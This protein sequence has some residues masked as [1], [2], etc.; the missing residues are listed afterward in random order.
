MIYLNSKENH[1]S[2][3]EQCEAACE[4]DKLCFQFLLHGKMCKLS[5]TIRLGREHVAATSEE[6]D[7]Y[8]SGWNVK[9]IRQW[10]METPCESAHWL[11]SNP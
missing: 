10:A 5:H 9:R 7:H 8:I 4:A 2:T 11:R 1:S 3:F 6:D